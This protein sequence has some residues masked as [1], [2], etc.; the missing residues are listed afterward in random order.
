MGLTMTCCRCHDHKYD[1]I[2]QKD[3]F[4]LYAFFNQTSETGRSG[5]G[6]TPPVLEYLNP[7]QRL[8]RQSLVRQRE[9][10]DAKLAAPDEAVDAQ[11]A[12]WEAELRE[13]LGTADHTI[14]FSPW[15]Q[16]G[17]FELDG[18]KAFDQ[19]L[20]PEKQVDLEATVRGQQWTQKESLADGR[21]N[22]LPAT[23]GATYLYRS[24]L[25]PAAISIRV[26]LGSD[27][28]I[29]V[30]LNG[31][32]VLENFAAR[33]AAE[34]QEV[35]DLELKEGRNDL[36]IKIVNTGG[37]AGYYFKK[38]GESSSGLPIDLVSAV[39]VSA[40][41]RSTAQQKQVRE[42]FRA[43]H[44][45][46]WEKSVTQRDRLNQQIEQLDRQQVSVMVM[47]QL[48][49][50][51]RRETLVLER[52]GYDKP[53]EVAVTADTP[54]VLPPLP[55]GSADRLALARWL[56]TPEHPLTARVTVNRYW[57]TFFGR[58]IVRS[59]EDFGS[60]GS[61]P[62]HPKLLDWLARRFVDS[63]WNVK[64]MHKLIVM[65]ATYRQKSQVR[66]EA[67]EIDPENVFLARA[68]RD[69]MPS[70]MLRDQ[71]LALG[72]L[73]DPMVGGPPVKP[74]QPEGI[75]AEA[76]FGKIRYQ[77]DQ[78]AALFRRSLYVFWRRIVGPTMFFDSAKRQT[79]EV[80]PTRTNTPLH[81][82][83]TLNETAFVESARAMAQRV[84]MQTGLDSERI[85][86]AF[87]M[88]TA[89]EPNEFEAGVLAERLAVLRNDY[90][91][92][93]DQAEALL[94]VGDSPR[95]RELDAV[96]HAAMTVICSTI[97]NLDEVL[98]GP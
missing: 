22:E 7:E 26:S 61:P 93:P 87:R 91:Q 34:D 41:E 15:W 4:R 5:R 45:P 40:D 97:L 72:G 8:R 27:D 89:R 75:W 39:L 83:T 84:M 90:A 14:E 86:R 65:S 63:G 96:E 24:I 30:F 71:A 16:L 29:K 57:Q 44:V 85:R 28:A 20:G 1:P 18:K 80:K 46:D 47:D 31:R 56:V 43:R 69:R 51:R 21:V 10:L 58:G 74:Y 2:S 33:A 95:D 82:L 70:W 9:A 48:P 23:I 37:I 53:T 42:A 73:L 94:S 38:V 52:G 81:A 19:D 6:K 62:S 66:D 32:Q 76:T 25:S 17:P 60:Q 67:Y 78:G 12:Q 98:S 54:D 88:A 36:L 92:H 13:R 11:Q 55:S 3:Y 68:P 49:A 64:R 50:E 79:C 77:A 35:I 59:T